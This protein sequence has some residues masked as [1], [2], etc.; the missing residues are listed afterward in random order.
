MIIDDDRDRIVE[1]LDR[2]L[3]QTQTF[4]GGDHAKFRDLVKR[5][6]EL[7]DILLAAIVRRPELSTASMRAYV[8]TTSAKIGELELLAGTS[9]GSRY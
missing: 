1:A 4:G 5:C 2:A 7:H 6:R 9:T 3:D 8:D